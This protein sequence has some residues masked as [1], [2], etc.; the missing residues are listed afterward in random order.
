MMLVVC[1]ND[2]E[3]DLKSFHKKYDCGR[4]SF[5]NADLLWQHLGVTPRL[6]HTLCPDQ[7]QGCT[8]HQSGT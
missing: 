8:R 6:G 7:R 5:G 3:V 2:T 1:L 4:V